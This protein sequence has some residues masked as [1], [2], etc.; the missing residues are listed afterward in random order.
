MCMCFCG[1]FRAPL[2]LPGVQV[3]TC[4]ETPP[5]T[6]SIAHPNSCTS[7]AEI[8]LYA[9][10]LGDFVS[11][12]ESSGIFTHKRREPK[13]IGE[14]SVATFIFP[15]QRL[16]LLVFGPNDPASDPKDNPPMWMMGR[17]NG[18]GGT[19]L[20]GWLPLCECFPPPGVESLGEAKSAVQKGRRIATLQAGR[21]RDLTGTFAFLSDGKGQVLASH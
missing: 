16:R 13:K 17:G 20:T 18:H 7:L 11:G 2:Q 12:M 5:S 14:H 21:I 3:E 6:M 8:V 4:F 19:E 10:N 1:E 15:K 9:Q